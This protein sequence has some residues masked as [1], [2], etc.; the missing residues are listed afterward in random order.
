[1]EHLFTDILENTFF[2]II[3]VGAF[4]SM[5]Y[6]FWLL[7]SPISALKLNQKINSTFSMRQKAK[8]LEKPITAEPIF[9]RHAKIFGILF[10]IGASYLLYLLFWQLDFEHLAKNL[11]GLTSLIWEWLLQAFKIF[12]SV[13]AITVLI[14]GFFMLIRP[15]HLKPLENEANRWVSTRQ[16]MQFMSKDLGQTDKLLDKYPRQFGAVILVAAAIILLNMD[17]FNI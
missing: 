13:M 4:L 8:P 3:I 15:S 10:I 6:G 14:I 5:L 9:Y 16:K 12:F 7:I 11:P 17:K 2:N 1:M